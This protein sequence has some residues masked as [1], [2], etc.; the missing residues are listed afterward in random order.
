MRLYTIGFTQR[1]AADFFGTLRRAGIRRLVDVRRRNSGQLAGFSKRE[2]L[3]FFLAELCGAEY[4]HEPRLAPSEELL[5]DYRKKRLG[6]SEYE[7]RFLALLAERRVERI[8]DP[9]LFDVP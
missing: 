8:I 4:V 9:S 3:P 2:D 6:W 1:S 7:P 5:G